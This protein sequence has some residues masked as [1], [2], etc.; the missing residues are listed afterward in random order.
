METS[1]QISCVRLPGGVLQSSI[2]CCQKNREPEQP[3][4]LNHRRRNSTHLSHKGV[5]HESSSRSCRCRSRSGRERLHPDPDRGGL[6]EREPYVSARLRGWILPGGHPTV[7]RHK[8]IPHRERRGQG[9][10]YHL[11]RTSLACK[12][13]SI[14]VVRAWTAYRRLAAVLH[15]AR[16]YQ[17]RC[18]AAAFRRPG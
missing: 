17:R 10:S 11:R 16:P 13:Q 18:G 8:P 9:V 1:A 2:T 6:A 15:A 7:W 4:G 3:N 14:G 5:Y 12:G